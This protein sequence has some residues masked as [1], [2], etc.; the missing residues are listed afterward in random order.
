MWKL[1][2]IYIERDIQHTHTYIKTT[3]Y[4]EM[5]NLKLYHYQYTVYIHKDP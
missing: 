5:F 1:C 3:S 4:I 2:H